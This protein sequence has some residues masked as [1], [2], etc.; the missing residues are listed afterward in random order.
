MLD[1]TPTARVETLLARFD[2]ALQAGK[3]EE[4]VTLFAAE[5]YWRDLVAF[6]WNIKTMEGR[7]ECG[8]CSPIA[9]PT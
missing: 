1:K 6:T 9:S 4:A 7:D 3:V 5:C 2:Q 8:T